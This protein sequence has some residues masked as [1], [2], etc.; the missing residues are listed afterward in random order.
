M[1]QRKDLKLQ[2]RAKRGMKSEGSE[3]TKRVRIASA[4]TLSAEDHQINIRKKN[5]VLGTQQPVVVTYR[6]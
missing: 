3:T 4:K 1:A 5:R 6:L 2:G